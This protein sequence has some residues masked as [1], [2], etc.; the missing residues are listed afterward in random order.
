MSVVTGAR[1]APASVQRAGDARQQFLHGPYTARPAACGRA[2]PAAGP[3]GA[4]APR[5]A[6][7]ARPRRPGRRARQRGRREHARCADPPRTTATLAEKAAPAQVRLATSTPP[8]PS[9][10]CFPAGD[11]EV[12]PR[13]DGVLMRGLALCRA[14]ARARTALISSGLCRTSDTAAISCSRYVVSGSPSPSASG[15]RRP[16]L[17]RVQDRHG[18]GERLGPAALEAEG[19]GG[20]VGTGAQVLVEVPGELEQRVADE[21]LAADQ[22]QLRGGAQGERVA[23]ARDG[24]HQPGTAAPVRGGGGGPA[25]AR[26]GTGRRA[27]TM[28]PIATSVGGDAGGRRGDVGV[29]PVQVV[30]GPAGHDGRELGRAE[31]QVASRSRCPGTSAPSAATRR[32][33]RCGS[34][35]RPA[36]S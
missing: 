36:G 16:G 4:R 24:P 15:E 35:S 33:R 18:G 26:A 7:R 30:P 9:P 27:A 10:T 12:V 11:P 5:A 14:A 22:P 2:G 1:R 17:D 13:E 19:D 21:G 25:S 23:A 20:V 6:R 32:G 29:Q 3:C 28:K 8:S 31:E 34:S